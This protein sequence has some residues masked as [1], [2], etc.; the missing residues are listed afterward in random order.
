MK[1]LTFCP[2]RCGGSFLMSGVI[3]YHGMWGMT[4]AIFARR[5][6]MRVVLVLTAGRKSL[7]L[8]AEPEATPRFAPFSNCFTD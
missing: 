2:L 3:C 1:N 8:R 5:L 7:W 4:G 6:F